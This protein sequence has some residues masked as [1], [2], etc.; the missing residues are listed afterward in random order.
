M[1]AA[2]AHQ[3]STS[4]VLCK[5]KETVRQS[6]GHTDGEMEVKV[7]DDGARLTEE[8]GGGRA[9]SDDGNPVL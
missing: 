7:A 6:A 8:D 5:G 3:I 9:S 4:V 2:T 1:M